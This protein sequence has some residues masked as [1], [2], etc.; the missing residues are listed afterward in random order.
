[1][2]FF[3]VKKPTSVLSIRLPD[4]HHFS[5]ENQE[6]KEIIRSTDLTSGSKTEISAR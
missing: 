5:K 3:T 6:A 4:Y 2:G 1:M